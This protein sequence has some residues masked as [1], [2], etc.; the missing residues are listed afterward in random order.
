MDDSKSYGENVV[1]GGSNPFASGENAVAGGESEKT[2]EG[3]GEQALDFS[4]DEV[5][6]ARL[7]PVVDF[8][9]RQ[10]KEPHAALAT[11]DAGSGSADE[12]D[13]GRIQ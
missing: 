5:R 8:K 12:V 10:L 9:G 13:G 3:K 2:G 4:L 7:V 1:A 11:P 6:E